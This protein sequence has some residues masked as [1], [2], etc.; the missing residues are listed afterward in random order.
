MAYLV[1]ARKYRP[2]RFDEMSG[3]EHVVRT[4]SNAHP[5]RPRRARLP[6]HRPARRGQDH[7]RPPARQGPE[8]REGPDRRALRRLHGLRG[9]RRRAR[10]V[11][12]IE[13]DGA[14]NNGVDNVRDIVE[15]V[16]YRPA[17]DR[18][19]VYIVDEV[20]MLSQGAFNALLKTL[21]EPP[22]HVKFIFA[23][24]DVAQASPRP[25]SRAA[26]ASTSAGSRSSRSPTG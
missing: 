20:H 10:S 21:E 11:D 18:F 7:R 26:S 25:S 24:T 14:S 3:Q 13:I 23:T 17:R 22:E 1:L 8:L 15:G 5:D 2:Q 12:V 4:L 16:K 6:L 19:K 9:D